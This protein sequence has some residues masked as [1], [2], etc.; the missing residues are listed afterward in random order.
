MNGV[1]DD[2][3]LSPNAFVSRPSVKK[4][5]IPQKSVGRSF[6]ASPEK[7][8][9][10][11]TPGAAARAKVSF[12]PEVDIPSRSASLFTSRTPGPAAHE[13]EASFAVSEG[14]TD[15]NITFDSPSLAKTASQSEWPSR[16]PPTSS[17]PAAASKPKHG[18][19][20]TIPSLDTLQKLPVSKLRAVPDLVVGRVGYGQV[21]FSQP[22][23]L[24]TLNSVEDLLGSLVRL[25]DRNATVYPEEWEDAKPPPGEGLNVPAVITLEGC[26][27]LDKASRRPITDPS[28][29]RVVQH[30]KRLRQLDGTS[31][32]DYHAEDGRWTFTVEEF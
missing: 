12:N 26:H 24:T 13:E 25:E 28:H 4:L 32:V 22:V 3:A 17:T 6:D 1:G 14:A 11:A 8:A 23:D 30:I 21:A 9:N 5:V 16:R 31:F 18:D 15:G 10:G 7:E 27:P 19:Y 20:F 29:P 2:V